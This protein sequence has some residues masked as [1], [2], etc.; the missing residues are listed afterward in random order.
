M[1][2]FSASGVGK[3]TK[4]I[5][6]TV[7][8]SGGGLSG[9]GTAYEVGAA[10]ATQSAYAILQVTSVSGTLPKLDVLVESDD[11]S[12]FA[13]GTTRFE[14]TQATAIGA[15]FLSLA[16]AITDEFWRVSF[17]TSGTSPVFNF[18]VCVGIL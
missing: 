17:S 7:L 2:K 16:G 12:G 9:V 18:V 15:E 14:F 8:H 10:S 13:S 11:A 6:G 1:H 4:L 3:G 5:R